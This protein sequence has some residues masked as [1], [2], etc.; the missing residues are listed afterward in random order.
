MILM[1][2]KRPTIK[3][4][5]SAERAAQHYFEK[6]DYLRVRIAFVLNA[7]DE[8]TLIKRLNKLCKLEEDRRN[9]LSNRNLR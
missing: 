2:R 8:V 9:D 5:E 1:A 7:N 6:W 4:V 3:D